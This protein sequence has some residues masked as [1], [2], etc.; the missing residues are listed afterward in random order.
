MKQK[1]GM[2]WL[3]VIH[4]RYVDSIVLP[5]WYPWT[6]S[7]L[8]SAHLLSCWWWIFANLTILSS[9]S[10]AN[11]SHVCCGHR[12]QWQY[13]Y[14]ELRTHFTLVPGSTN[15]ELKLSQQINNEG[16]NMSPQSKHS[17]ALDTCNIAYWNLYVSSCQAHY[18]AMGSTVS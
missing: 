2:G 5:R 18:K 6:S 14:N 12:T 16:W 3:W 9:S 13:L 8:Q 15:F 7:F 11:T 10:S 17:I 1:M 4:K